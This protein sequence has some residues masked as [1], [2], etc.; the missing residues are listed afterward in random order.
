MKSSDQLD[1]GFRDKYDFLAH[2]TGT[3][4]NRKELYI[5]SNYILITTRP[6]IAFWSSTR[7]LFI[8]LIITLNLSN[9]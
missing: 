4:F 7:E 5:I 9:S 8:T 6:L 3:F 2:S 1:R